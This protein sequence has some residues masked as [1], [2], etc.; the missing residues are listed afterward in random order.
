MD[1]DKTTL[2]KFLQ[3]I[4]HFEVPVYQRRYYWKPELAERFY[5]DVISAGKN[6]STLS[7]MFGSIVVTT[8]NLNLESGITTARI[9][10]GQQRI[11]TSVILYKALAKY[12]ES[13]GSVE[14]AITSGGS[15]DFSENYILDTYVIN[16][17]FSG[18]THFKAIPGKSD[19]E[20]YLDIMN[21]SINQ[22]NG[23]NNDYITQ[24]Y[25]LF[26]RLMAS[27][28]P[29][30]KDLIA[31][32]GKIEIVA[33]KLRDGIDDPQIIFEN[34]NSLGETLSQVDLIR[35]DILLG[36]N[37]DEQKYVSEQYWNKIEEIFPNSESYNI[38]DFIVSFMDI[39]GVSRLENEHIFK[40]F[41][42]HRMHYKNT[43]ELN[44]FMA[45]LLKYATYYRDIQDDKSIRD[46]D[47]K[48]ALKSLSLFYGKI[49]N[50]R[51][52]AFYLYSSYKERRI[53]KK[54]F[55]STVSMI[56]SAMVRRIVMYGETGDKSREIFVKILKD[57]P[58][59]STFLDS[60]KS[61]LAG[62]DSKGNRIFPSDDDFRMDLRDRPIYS[63][64]EVCKYVLYKLEQRKNLK[65]HLDFDNLTI[66]HIM[67][68]TVE[69]SSSWQ[70]MLGSDWRR[71]HRSR[72]HTIGNLTLTGYNSELGNKSFEEK[73]SL[74]DGKG[75]NSSRVIMTREICNITE[76][77]EDRILERADE[78]VNLALTV[79]PS[80]GEF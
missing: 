22:D 67:P 64:R 38:Q 11:I 51:D 80:I 71:I 18:N 73:K 76:W 59:K 55:L 29:N 17:H 27:E 58:D 15:V 9:I 79:W 3:L 72:I 19:R 23:E 35:N 65:E 61:I 28:N 37:D 46:N 54:D 69:S 47:I 21:D 8:P 20:S 45:K 13:T 31:G 43:T 24:N 10:D 75:Y 70:N 68:Q 1:V 48:S 66:E 16:K 32:L 30:V 7:H 53:L 34:L 33:V 60:I 62:N 39:E 14:I 36:L 4:S 42:R 77:T 74:V 52:L 41:R 63:Y 6:P 25:L 44:I 2:P 78:L 56:E 40:R 50:S 26:K 49:I 57:L 5:R 12:I